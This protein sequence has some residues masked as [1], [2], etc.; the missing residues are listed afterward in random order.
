L[1]WWLV[2][3]PWK[4]W[5]TVTLSTAFGHAFLLIFVGELLYLLTHRTLH[6]APYED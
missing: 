2:Y 6:R 5:Q 3:A 1:A 4:D